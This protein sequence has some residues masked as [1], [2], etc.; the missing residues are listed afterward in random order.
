MAPAEKD[1]TRK[2]YIIRQAS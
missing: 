1:L 2:L